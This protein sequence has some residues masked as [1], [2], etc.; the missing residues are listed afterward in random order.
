MDFEAVTSRWATVCLD[1]CH[2]G[3]PLSNE[4]LLDWRNWNKSTELKHTSH[5]AEEFV[6]QQKKTMLRMKSVTV[7]G[8]S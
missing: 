7:R 3:D 2:R 4:C 6:G 1:S 5:E 8:Q